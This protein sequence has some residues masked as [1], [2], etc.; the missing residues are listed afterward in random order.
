MKKVEFN[1]Q[2][3]KLKRR[4]SF[5]FYFVLATMIIIMVTAV[6][7]SLLTDVI[8]NLLDNSI[9]IPDFV[10]IMIIS[11]IVGLILAYLI[12]KMLLFPL[13]KLQNMM[14]EVAKGNLNIRT[15]EKSIFDEIEDIYHYFNVMMDELRA[16]ETIQSD[17]I[18]NVSH[19]FKTPLNTIDGYASLLMDKNLTEKEKEAYINKIHYNVSRMNELIGNILLLSKLDNQTIDSKK[20]L[21]S[22]DE[23][24]RQSI[25]YLEPKW[26][27]KQIIFDVDLDQINY[28]G[29]E[30]IM[31]HVWNNLIDNAIKF[32]PQSGIIKIKLKEIDN[33]IVYF[34]EDDGPGIP[35]QAKNYIFNKFYQSDTSHKAEG[36]GLGLALAKKILDISDGTIE[37]ENLYPKGC[38]FKVT[39]HQ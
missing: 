12:G 36:N 33:Q 1:Y 28:F 37:T 16:T 4:R 27:S 26:D 24:I 22:L 30:G 13:K 29:N 2:K 8:S 23:Q 15:D 6:I 10:F 11:L 31:M 5:S 34:I 9:K 14:D 39:L 18:S 3:W 20:K 25:V 38:R 35:E 32:S 7:S 19:E 21:Y 17:F